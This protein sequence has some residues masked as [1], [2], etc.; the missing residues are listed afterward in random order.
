MITNLAIIILF[1]ICSIGST[2]EFGQPDF[3]HYVKTYGKKY[4]DAEYQER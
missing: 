4:S 2:Q 3:A 1:C